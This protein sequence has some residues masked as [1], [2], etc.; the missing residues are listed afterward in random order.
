MWSGLLQEGIKSLIAHLVEK[1]STKLE[2]V[3]YVDTFQA[4]KLK[5]EQ[6]GDG[7]KP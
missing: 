2:G 4:L 3:D 6:V 7:T 1:F 5:Y